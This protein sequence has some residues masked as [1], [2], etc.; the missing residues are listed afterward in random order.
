MQSRWGPEAIDRT[1]RDIRDSDYPFGGITVV[2]GGDFQQ[3]LPVVIRGTREQV[4]SATLQHSHLWKHMQVLRLYQNMRLES[5]DGDA[6][7]FAA[8]LLDVGHGQTGDPS[9]AFINIPDSM[10]SANKDAL[11]SSVYGDI[12]PYNPVPP[13]EYFLHRTILAPR[14]EEVN[15]M[16]GDVLD[17]M[18]GQTHSF[19]SA[20]SIEA[21]EDGPN[22]EINP[23]ELTPE[24]LRAINQSNLPL[25]ELHV[26]EGCPLI[27]LRNLASTRGLCN[28]TR[29]VLLRV[30]TH[31]LEVKII[32]GDHDGEIALLPRIVLNPGSEA[33][34]AFTLRRRQF[35][36]RLAFAMTINK[37]QGQSVKFVGLDLRASVFSHG[38]LYVALSR[39]TSKER[40]KACLPENVSNGVTRNIVYPEILLD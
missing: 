36:V 17:R 3:I 24:F 22:S 26:K 1:C 6:R 35:P 40:I 13:P 38:Q 31:V 21:E 33:N 18:P 16:N 37:G 10:Q 34:F 25:G 20:D 8:W 15:I 9:S 28:G 29:L 7:N 30:S 27:L 39:C 4:V 14:N 11:I 32:G 2:F 19:F 12:T 5:Q 23:H